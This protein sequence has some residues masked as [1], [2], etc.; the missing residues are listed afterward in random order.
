M[1][2]TAA[3][4][5][6]VI[7]RLREWLDI[8]PGLRMRY[9]FEPCS[10]VHFVALDPTSF[11]MDDDSF[12]DTQLAL[13]SDLPKA[14]PDHGMALFSKPEYAH[15]LGDDTIE[16]L[17]IM[18]NTAAA[19]AFVQHRLREWLDLF[20]GLRMRYYFSWCSDVHFVALD[21]TSFPMDDK[22]FLREQ[23]KLIS[24]LKDTYEG[25]GLAIFYE[26]EYLYLLGEGTIEIEK[27]LQK[28]TIAVHHKKLDIVTS[29]K[30][31]INEPVT[32]SRF[33][34]EAVKVNPA[35]KDQN[36]YNGHVFVNRIKTAVAFSSNPIYNCSITQAA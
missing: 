27:E 16:I 25:H 32:M 5:E 22:P 3:A 4:K 6:F 29:M 19:K 18:D 8:F 15:F 20:P 17:P 24:D 7:A 23:L 10:D 21:P 14:Y 9:Y 34:I 36:L 13:I 1:D 33:T 31:Y 35:A 11:P 30:R 12:L 28:Q 2:N 26:A